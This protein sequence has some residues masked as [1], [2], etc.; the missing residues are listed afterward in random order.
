M[1]SLPFG[2]MFLIK[3]LTCYESSQ[4]LSFL[5][6]SQMVTPSENGGE[7]VKLFHQH[8]FP[9]SLNCNTVFL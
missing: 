6:A 3:S 7:G 5:F 9:G 2:Y 8:T 4:Y 1:I